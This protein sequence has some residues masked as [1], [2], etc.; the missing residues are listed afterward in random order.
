[1]AET[2]R[3]SL[4]RHRARLNGPTSRARG[5]DG[6]VLVLT[7]MLMV[8][9]LGMVALAIDTG[10]FAQAREQAQSAADS[11]A[12]AAAEVLPD[13]PGSVTA[14]ASTYAATND[15]GATVAVA[16]PYDGDGSDV[17]VSVT[18][19]VPATF[20]QILGVDQA[21]VSATA[22]AGPN[23]A[24]ILSDGSFDSPLYDCDPFC[25]VNAGSPI[26]AWTADSNG[27]D[28]VTC[29]DTITYGAP[30]AQ[31]YISAPPGDAS[32]AQVID[33]NGD[34]AGG[35]F[36]DIQ[37]VVGD[38]YTV[39]YK[40]SGNPTEGQQLMTGYVAWGDTNGDNT[41]ATFSY[42]LP[43]SGNTWVQETAS[44]VAQYATTALAFQSTS[45]GAG[46]LSK[47][48]PVIADVSVHDTTVD[49]IK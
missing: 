32:D 27:V 33:L 1:M 17:Q 37:T 20:G 44:F 48:G 26:G 28:L 3:Q 9:M 5:E 25:V 31:D 46:S 47:A 49:L 30:G 40:L 4:L 36:Q 35:I 41:D 29:S 23:D 13:T 12:L 39:S 22:V 7:A 19:T 42:Q 16:T 8:A 2:W 15:P 45:Y 34:Q 38:T 6:V 10:R 11:A 24:D 43:A 21:T 18:K 14:D